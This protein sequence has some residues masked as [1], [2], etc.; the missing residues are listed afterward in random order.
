[1]CNEYQSKFI[2]ESSGFMSRVCD[3]YSVSS[4]MDSRQ[5]ACWVVATRGLWWYV[6][7]MDDSPH[8][9]SRS[10]YET[11]PRSW[12]PR[13]RPLRVGRLL[14]VRPQPSTDTTTWRVVGAGQWWW[15]PHLYISSATACS[16]PGASCCLLQLPSSPPPSSTQV[17][18]II[19]MLLLCSSKKVLICDRILISWWTVVR[20]WNG[21]HNPRSNGRK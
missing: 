21:V 13:P 17:S 3:W 18:W 12:R 16:C 10:G 7:R 20:D 8:S 1:M 11:R 15:P 5:W 19:M 9:W 2:Q 4:A 14:L 6:W